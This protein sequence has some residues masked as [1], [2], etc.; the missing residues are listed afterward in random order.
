MDILEFQG[1]YRWLSN[2]WPCSVSLEGMQ[3]NSVEAAYVA[4]KTTDAAVRKQVQELAKPGDCKRF[5]RG[6]KLRHDWETVKLQVM[7]EL[8]RQKFTKGSALAS[9]LIA[10]GTSKIE[11]GNRW[12]DTFWGVCR[13]EGS[14]HLGKLLMKI[15]T[16]LISSGE[17]YAI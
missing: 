6:I 15:R 3:F 13:G 7:E 12:G 5:G 9:K 16:E 1:D 2:F 8:L 4:A 14:N 11:E 17:G 10:T